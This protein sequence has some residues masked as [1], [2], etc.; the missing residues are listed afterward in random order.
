MKLM[1]IEELK[2]F[3]KIYE[4]G[5]ATQ[6]AEELFISRQALRNSISNLE[7]ELGAPLIERTSHGFIPT[8]FGNFFIEEA[9]QAIQA[10]DRLSNAYARYQLKYEKTI[11][12]LLPNAALPN[13][14][15][16]KTLVK[17]F[18]KVQQ[19]YQVEVD[20]KEYQSNEEALQYL[21]YDCWYVP[22]EEELEDCMRMDIKKVEFLVCIGRQHPLYKSDKIQWTDLKNQKF[23]TASKNTYIYRYLR[24]KGVSD[25]RIVFDS[26]LFDVKKA[27]LESGLVIGFSSESFLKEKKKDYGTDIKT[28]HMDPVCT[29]NNSLYIKKAMLEQKDAVKQLVNYIETSICKTKVERQQV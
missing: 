21:D 16:L 20:T 23:V 27:I 15:F 17:N 10:T 26:G 18:N 14:L 2:Y 4:T 3:I 7:T 8:K 5:N 29:V 11:R 28:M 6:A 13:L 25:R 1:T 9:R 19:E 12:M 22:S 24:N